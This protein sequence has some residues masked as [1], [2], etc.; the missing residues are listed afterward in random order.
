[1]RDTNNIVEVKKEFWTR[2]AEKTDLVDEAVRLI[3]AGAPLRTIADLM[4]IPMAFQKIK[5][6]SADLAFWVDDVPDVQRLVH[7]YMPE[8][9]PRMKL[10][11]RC[12]H[13][14]RSV[15]PEFVEWVAKH[16]F[17]IA[18][19]AREVLSFLI[20]LGDWVEACY[21]S[22]ASVDGNLCS[23]RGEQFVVRPFSPDMSLRTVTK[24]SEEWHEAV[25][26]GMSGPSY[27]FPEP[28]SGAGQSFG[29]EIVPIDTPRSSIAKGT[30]CIT[31]LAP[32]GIECKRARRI[33]TLF[34]RTKNAWRRWNY[35][36]KAMTSRSANFA[37]LA[38]AKCRPKLSAR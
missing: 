29:Y 38:I 2:G 22:R 20:D 28:W 31:A 4:C 16:S 34:A 15:G 36:G 30:C 10:W 13:Q 5:P 37:D 27:D 23:P 26:N 17:E 33:F 21:L 8:S 7:A 35:F 25:A 14:A 24:L 32:K 1:M 19:S 18:G 3:N 11:L 12:V 9:L 6:G